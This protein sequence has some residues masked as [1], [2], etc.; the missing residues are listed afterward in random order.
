M[1]SELG[2][3]SDGVYTTDENCFDNLTGIIEM[4]D[5]DDQAGKYSQ[6]K[7]GPKKRKGFK[8]GGFL[9][10][11]CRKQLAAAGTF[12]SD[13]IPLFEKKIS[14]QNHPFLR[15]AVSRLSLQCNGQFD[16]YTIWLKLNYYRFSSHHG[17]DGRW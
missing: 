7:F 1:T 10:G 11:S 13:I 8:R 3:M 16:K 15:S 4:V 17:L 14:E 6:R 5:R 2:Y 12:N 9:A